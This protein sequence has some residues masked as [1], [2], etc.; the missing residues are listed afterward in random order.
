MTF[1]GGRGGSEGAGFGLKGT[2][3]GDAADAV[4]EEAR[5]KRGMN[6]A[7]VDA[8][9]LHNKVK[10]RDETKPARR[11]HIGNVNPTAT[12]EEFARVLE[13]RIRTLYPQAV[14]WHYP[15]DKKGRVDER[16]AP[17]TRVI[18][19][20]YLNDKG[21]GFLE[22]TALEDVPAILALNGVR[23]N[24]SATRFRRPK[25][26]DPD[27]N[28]LVRD[29]SYRNVFDGVFTKVLS[30][31]VADS[32]TKVFVGG[33]HPR[34]LT[35]LDLLEIVSSFGALTAFRCDED[36]VGRCVDG[37]AWMEYEEGESVAAKA[38]AGLNGYQMRGK[39]LVAAL[40]TPRAQVSKERGAPRRYTYEVPPTVE[41]LLKPPQRVLALSNV[42][43]RGGAME[44][45]AAATEDT[46]AECAGFGN[47][48]STHVP[49]DGGA[50]QGAEQ[51]AEGLEEELDTLFVE[52]ARVETA[53]IAAHAL[54]R[55][56]YDGRVVEC[57]FFPLTE[58]QRM[59]GKGFP[60][61][62]VEEKQAAALKMMDF[63]AG[64]AGSG[65]GRLAA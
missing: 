45:R 31:K 62:T 36:G 5:D 9:L 10:W 60:P 28:P 18:E 26:Y 3:G 61:R 65:T 6:A 4:R 19:H 37:R 40:A 38:I 21:F 1:F 29:G 54:H 27:A 39:P 44:D 2:V 17:G 55:R 48:L 12:A 59:F 16:R 53:T 14:P 32:P 33:V 49:L 23:V 8:L 47:V 41:P 30:D 35:K 43:V 24:G 57:R 42:L 34:A 22:T 13:T 11:V 46:L 58:Y 51:G 25:D 7:M 15:L 50:D 52:F 20:L 56:E 63:L 64:T